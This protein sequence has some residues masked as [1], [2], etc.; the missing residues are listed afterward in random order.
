MP[1]PFTYYHRLKTQ[2]EESKASLQAGVTRS[3]AVAGILKAARGGGELAN[4]GV[5]GRLG[6][7][8]SISEQ[9]D[10]A[11]S[12][13]CGMLDHIVVQTTAGAQRCLSFLRKH[14]LGRANF[15]PL[16]KM[17][18]GAHDRTVETPE[19]APR[20]FDV[21]TPSN[22]AITPALYLGVGNTL[23]APDLET[24]TKWAYDF[25]KRWRVV[26]I[27][28]NLIELS[29]TMQGGGKTVRRGGMRLLVR[30]WSYFV[31]EE[32]RNFTFNLRIP[33]YYPNFA[34]F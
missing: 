7:L 10:V 14:G 13:A 6:D 9:Y 21:I 25:G 5:L 8:A 2:V 4:V 33:L 23:V 20:L 3:Q 17:K 11:V 28:G 12:T 34:E 31:L 18:K 15:I 19:G 32:F 24:A 29:G 26:T 30:L 16:D 1:P 22:F 27:D